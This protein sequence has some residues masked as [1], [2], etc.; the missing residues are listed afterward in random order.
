MNEVRWVKPQTV[1]ISSA[2]GRLLL[3]VLHLFPPWFSFLFVFQTR[4]LLHPYL[5]RD[6]GNNVCKNTIFIL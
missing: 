1:E 4:L 6:Y 5:T 3:C 2:E